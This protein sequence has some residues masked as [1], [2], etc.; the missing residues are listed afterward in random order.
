MTHREPPFVR[1]IK[2]YDKTYRV[3]IYGYLL[4]PEEWTERFARR[5]E[6]E[7][8]MGKLTSDHL[9]V[10]GSLRRIFAETGEIPTGPELCRGYCQLDVAGMQPR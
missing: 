7:M 8:G 2:Y 5:K 4:D 10:L 6:T 9:G 3:D 1:Y